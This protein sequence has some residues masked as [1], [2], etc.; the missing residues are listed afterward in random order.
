MLFLLG[1]QG[2]GIAVGLNKVETEREVHGIS[3]TRSRCLV[4]RTVIWRLYR[5]HALT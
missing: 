3:G 5:F 1:T 4:M 2:P